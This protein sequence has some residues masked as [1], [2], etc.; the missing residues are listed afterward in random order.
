MNAP[1]PTAAASDTPSPRP[2]WTLLPVLLAAAAVALIVVAIVARGRGIGVDMELRYNEIRCVRAGINPFD[3]WSGAA[4]PMEFCRFDQRPLTGAPVHTYPPW[5]YTLAM[6]LSFLSQRAAGN[7]VECILVVLAALVAAWCFRRGR[8]L[9]GGVWQCGLL[10]AAAAL[11]TG[12]PLHE[13][14][15]SQNYY[16]LCTVATLGLAS[17]LNR[18]RQV[19]GGICWAL[20]MVKPQY[21]V[22]F[23]IP[24]LWR[25]QFVT[26][27]VAVALCLALSVPPALLTHTSLPA[28]ILQAGRAGSEYFIRS[29]LIPS[30]AFQALAARFGHW[31]P[32]A[33]SAALGI[34]LTLWMT[35]GMRRRRDWF[36]F[37]LPTVLGTTIWTYC[38]MYGHVPYA[39]LLCF[40]AERLWRAAPGRETALRALVLVALMNSLVLYFPLRM[41]SGMWIANRLAPDAPRETLSH[42]ARLAD[43]AFFSVAY[44]ANYVTVV[45][46]A[47]VCR[48]AARTSPEEAIP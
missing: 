46:L 16:L 4:T 25:R 5:E 36:E 41:D 27:G 23:A 13:E 15:R 30:V 2:R 22:L 47:I 43:I 6:P 10:C 48:R 18:G 17:A 38:L 26:F 8:D 1:A 3:V 20:M 35:W 12:L 32:A 39:L 21:G 44:L 45:W 11:L 42:L 28:I 33:G 31:L 24:I 29:G 37:L 9:S 34:G 40:A 19:I 7:A 14:F